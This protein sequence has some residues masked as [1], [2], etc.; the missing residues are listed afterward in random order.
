[1]AEPVSTS[2]RGESI[3]AAEFV[4]FTLGE[5]Y[6][7][8]DIMSLRE[9]RGWSPVTPLPDTPD[10]VLGVVNLRGTV[11]PII[12]L[13]ARFGLAP[14][15]PTDRSIIMITSFEGRMTGLLADSASNIIMIDRNDIQPAP[16]YGTGGRN[17]F[18]SGL[19]ARGEQMIGLISLGDVIGDVERIAA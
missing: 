1:M 16:S 18:V 12:D 2:P 19:V 15:E 3:D 14:S 10:H 7:C 13:S 11:L 17:E 5:Q 9:I 6:F 8:I 4:S